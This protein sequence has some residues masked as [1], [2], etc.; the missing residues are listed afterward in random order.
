MVGEEATFS[1]YDAMDHCIT[2]ARGIYTFYRTD[3]GG[4]LKYNQLFEIDYSTGEITATPIS[5]DQAGTYSYTMRLV[6]FY[7]Y[8]KYKTFEIVITPTPNDYP[9]MPDFFEM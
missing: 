7:N 5:N 2:N 1:I 3:G 4:D 6:S 8:Y 9:Y